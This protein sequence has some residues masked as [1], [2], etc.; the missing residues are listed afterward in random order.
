MQIEENPIM[1]ESLQQIFTIASKLPADDQDRIA[2]WLAA[3]LESDQKWDTLFRSSP[4]VLENL[5][6]EALLED[7]C[8]ETKDWPQR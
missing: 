3:E 4:N 5:A 8:G 6:R 2:A 1:T 7:E